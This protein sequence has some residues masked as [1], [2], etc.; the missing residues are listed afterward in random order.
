M[1][2]YKVII[3]DDEEELRNGI[4]RKIDWYGNGFEVVGS[5]ENG[6]EAY[7]LC[8]KYHPDL[9]ITDIKMPFMTGLEL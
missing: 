9:V 2:L 4:I 3:A 1:S 8:K 5:A 6:Q 7:D